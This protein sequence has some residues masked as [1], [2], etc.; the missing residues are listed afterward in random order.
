MA[1]VH[2]IALIQLHPKP[3]APAENFAK[4]ESFIKDAAKEGC[5][6]A[7]L[8]E[9]H[10]TSW[11][12]DEPNF[13]DSCADSALYLEKYQ[14]L[15]KELSIC[16]VPGTIVELEGGSLHNIA[17]FIS[18]N[19][20]ILG[21]YQKKNLWHPERRH[22]VSS[23]KQPHEAFDTSLGRVGLLICWDIAFPEAFRE[24]ISDGAQII[25]VPTF[26]SM[27][28]VSDEGYALNPDGEALFLN[29]TVVSRAFE[30]TCAIVFVNAGGPPEKGE[31][32]S[33]AGLSQVSVP[34]IG[35]LGKMDRSEGMSIVDL[36]MNIL[37]IA[38]DNYKVRE[39]MR[40]E[41][42]HYAYTQIR[43]GSKL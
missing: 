29:S 11:V 28:D 30:N 21:R 32:T 1:P 25:C 24:L 27:K 23:A 41:G 18:S 4:A 5:S 8:P 7:V 43:D 16:I 22:L 13:K 6:L 36:D 12:P 34:H 17:Y 20:E 33:F 3:L 19:G 39:D 26:W 37:K 2:K 31:K 10:L 42:W 38:E 14:Q 40:G 9:Y 35:S 15:A